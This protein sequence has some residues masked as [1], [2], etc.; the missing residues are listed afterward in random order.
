MGQ[1]LR[2]KRAISKPV[3]TLAA[4]FNPDRRLTPRLL[5]DREAIARNY[6]RLAALAPGA[7]TAAAVKADAYGLGAPA[8]AQCLMRSGCRS[9]F[10]ATVEEGADLR[11]SLGGGEAEIWVLNGYAPAQRAVYVEQRLGAVLNR[12]EEVEA[13]LEAPA[14]PCALHVDTGMNRL[15]LPLAQAAALADAPGHL[16]DLDLRLVMSHLACSEA[17]DAAMNARQRD[18]FTDLI[19]RFPGVRASMANTGGVFLG[20]GYHF[21]MTRPGIGLYGAT[22]DPAAQTDLEPVAVL[23]A[24]ILQL[25]EIAAGESVGYGASYVADKPR[26]I[27]T[28]AAGYADGLPRALAGRGYARI[29]GAKVPLLGR[30]SM[31][32][33]VI[34]VTDCAAAVRGGAQAHFFGEDLCALASLAGTLPYEILTG[35]GSRAAR[36]YGGAP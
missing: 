2:V 8:V 14:G 23:E 21:D 30:V 5:V 4:E 12:S 27:A 28:V 20:S 26:L 10:V 36:T 33:A 18:A 9:F 25:R 16:A 31:D 19:G 24:P 22:A 35:I 15:G 7:E 1:T 3:M 34:D 17:S 13:F 6:A 32:L 11:R 29:D